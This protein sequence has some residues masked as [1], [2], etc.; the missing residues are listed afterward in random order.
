[1]QFFTEYNRPPSDAEIQ[2]Y[3]SIT[4]TAGYL[5][6]HV[7]IENLI[8]AGRRLDAYRKEAYEF[9]DGV[10]PPDYVDP[11]RSPGFDMADGTRIG[12]EVEARLRYQAE[13]KKDTE[14]EKPEGKENG[15]S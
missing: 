8:D 9:P 14:V 12:R 10:V 4:E 1:M 15:V 11:T 7:Q 5:P 6:A 3:V 13:L 2:D